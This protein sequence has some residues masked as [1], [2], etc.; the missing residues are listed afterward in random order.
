MRIGVQINQVPTFD[1]IRQ[2]STRT[3]AWRRTIQHAHQHLA[4]HNNRHNSCKDGRYRHAS[5]QQKQ[6]HFDRGCHNADLQADCLRVCHHLPVGARPHICIQHLHMTA[7]LCQ[8]RQSLLQ[9]DAKERGAGRAC[10]KALRR[11][12]KRGQWGSA[13]TRATI[14]RNGASAMRLTGTRDVTV[15]LTQM[16][17]TPGALGSARPWRCRPLWGPASRAHSAVIAWPVAASGCE[18]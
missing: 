9:L 5:A 6:I 3:Q 8:L 1:S 14:A 13:C 2:P 4:C 12:R 15:V 16:W 17:C 18:S 11:R 7:A 10:H